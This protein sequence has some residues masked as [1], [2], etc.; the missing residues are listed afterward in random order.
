M[1]VRIYAAFSY[2]L[3][4]TVTLIEDFIQVRRV[5]LIARS[6]GTTGGVYNGS[7][8]VNQSD[9]LRLPKHFLINFLIII[10]LLVI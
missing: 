8:V 7:E 4:S 10:N 6:V 2:L 1:E 9:D 3:L 5:H